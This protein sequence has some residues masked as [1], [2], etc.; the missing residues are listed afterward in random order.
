MNI[1]F[2]KKNEIKTLATIYNHYRNNYNLHYQYPALDFQID[3]VIKI[4]KDTENES[5]NIVIETTNTGG[6]AIEIDEKKSW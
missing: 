6:I 4:N 3:T 1:K 2:K 5:N